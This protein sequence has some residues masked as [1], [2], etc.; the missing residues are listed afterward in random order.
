MARNTE[1]SPARANGL[2][3][4]GYHHGNLKEALVSAARVLILEKG[5]HGF[6]L[7]EAARLAG[8]SPA[9][10]YRHFKDREALLA[11]VARRGYA[12]FSDSLEKAWAGGEPD[13]STAFRRL[14]HAYLDFALTERAYY[15]A[16]FEAELPPDGDSA[17]HPAIHGAA[18]RAYRT[19]S[20]AT[21][22]LTGD[23]PA[24]RPVPP[25]AVFFHIWS[26]AH[27]AATLGRSGGAPALS[28]HRMLD[29]GVELYLKGLGIT[30]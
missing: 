28:R 2:R 29:L 19:L 14:G 13:R 20:R 25:E 21:D 8:V 11:E 4:S 16:M 30:A 22:R 3:K 6:S 1:K 27:G 10:P 17:F 18:D 5:P 26:L 23:D 7:I 15:A 12:K 24:D 9:A